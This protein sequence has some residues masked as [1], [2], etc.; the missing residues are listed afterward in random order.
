MK[1]IVEKLFEH[2]GQPK[3]EFQS[4][5]DPGYKLRNLLKQNGETPIMLVLDDVW[6][7]SESFVQK[8][9]VPI[10]DLK[11]VVTSRVRL[12]LESCVSHRIEKLSH[13]DSMTLFL[14]YAQLKGTC[15]QND[16]ADQVL[17]L[18]SNLSHGQY[19][20]PVYSLQSV[21]IL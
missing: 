20:T 5:E 18:F 15:P 11:I 12:D 9:M 19:I 2:F 17:S 21:L 10:S 7:G 1:I 14:H 8:F 6:P 4:N 13:T 16:L 3:P